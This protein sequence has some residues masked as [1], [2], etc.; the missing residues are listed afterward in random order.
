[1]TALDLQGS[2]PFEAFISQ[3]EW[4]SE[5]FG[6][7]FER[8]RSF[9][10][11]DE[12][13][14]SVFLGRGV[15]PRAD[16]DGNNNRPG[17]DLSKYQVVRSGDLVFNKLRTWQGGFGASLYN[18]IISPA[19]FV[20]R[21]L[22][23]VESRFVDYTLHS[24]IY[25]SE[26]T[27]ISK[28]MP[29][30]QFDISWEDLRLLRLVVPPTEKQRRIVEFLD[31]ETVET[32][33]L[34][35]KYELLIEFLEE[36]RT[37]IISNAVTRGINSASTLVASGND[38]IGEIPEHWQIGQLR[39]FWTV[40]DC[41]HVT[42]EFVENGFPMASVREVQQFEVNLEN[43]KRTTENWFEKMIAGNR[44]PRAG[45]L[46]FCRNVS[47]GACAFV[48]SDDQFAL[49]QDVCL[50]RSRTE[51]QRYLNYVMRSTMMKDQIGLIMIGATFNRINVSKVEALVVP[52]PP[53]DQQDQ[54]VSFLDG[55]MSNIDMQIASVRS[56]IELLAERR[57]TIITSAILGQVDVSGDR[58]KRK[59]GV[60]E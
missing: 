35:S 59:N 9:N 25:L 44:Q 20:C 10:R 40:I 50:I 8:R 23:R 14:L 6:T 12:P 13:L 31:N 27:R 56:A 32:D 45:D 46:I 24:H 28:W 54:I 2:A 51:N 22:E 3:S 4:T 5:R 33:V 39:R 53:R 16:G 17:D 60:A 18:G 57:A 38:L 36:K 47:V 30:S 37:A 7:L 42:V 43:A 41:K 48:A 19:Y 49:G 58:C 26:L 29:P 11:P 1:M 55:E 34:V 21:P 52:R 15:V